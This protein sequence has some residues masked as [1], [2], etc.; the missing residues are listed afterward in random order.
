MDSEQFEREKKVFAKEAI[1]VVVRYR[2]AEFAV[3]E[4][5]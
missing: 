3:E 4:P 2:A 5:V 1:E